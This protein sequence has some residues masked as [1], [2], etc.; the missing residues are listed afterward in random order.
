MVRNE[1]VPFKTH[2]QRK[3]A[4]QQAE[5]RA[6]ME[7]AFPFQKIPV[8]QHLI[9]QFWNLEIHEILESRARSITALVSA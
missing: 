1:F 6:V 9:Y 7:R 2:R 4:G 8:F 3:T 5:T